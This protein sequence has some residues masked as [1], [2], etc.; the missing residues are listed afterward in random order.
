MSRSYQTR[1]LLAAR[2]IR[3][4]QAAHTH[5]F[6]ALGPVDLVAAICGIAAEAAADVHATDPQALPTCPRC[7]A[8]DPRALKGTP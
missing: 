1:A 5:T 4:D 2:Y 3:A 7:L 6:L 8:R